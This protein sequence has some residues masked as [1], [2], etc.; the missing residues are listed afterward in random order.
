[1]LENSNGRSGNTWNLR[2]KLW[3]GWLTH[4]WVLMCILNLTDIQLKQQWFSLT[5]NIPVWLLC[6]CR[7]SL[8]TRLPTLLMLKKVG[9]VLVLPEK[10]CDQGEVRLT[11]NRHSHE[12]VWFLFVGN[13]SI[14]RCQSVP[15]LNAQRCKYCSILFYE[16]GSLA[17][18][19]MPREFKASVFLGPQQIHTGIPLWLNASCTQTALKIIFSQ[20]FC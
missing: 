17:A 11:A 4:Q 13:K 15:V 8:P 5:R 16:S 7:I 14:R 19:C 12:V 1:M 20:G 3:K 10:V 2:I 6:N 9:Y 18:C